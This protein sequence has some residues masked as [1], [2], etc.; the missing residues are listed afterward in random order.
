LIQRA[1]PRREGQLGEALRQ[2]LH[3][4]AV[5][6][7]PEHFPSFFE[8]EQVG[9]QLLQLRLERTAGRLLVAED[10]GELRCGVRLAR[11]VLG[12]LPLLFVTK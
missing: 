2:A 9:A 6:P 12:T 11:Q 5:A 4:F 7:S 10:A 1:A 8:C 3:D